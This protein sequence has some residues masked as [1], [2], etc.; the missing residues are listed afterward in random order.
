MEAPPPQYFRGHVSFITWSYSNA[1]LSLASAVTLRGEGGVPAFLLRY[2]P[3][4][5]RVNSW[6]TSEA[7]LAQM[8]RGWLRF[9]VFFP[10]LFLITLAI[11]TFFLSLECEHEKGEPIIFSLETKQRSGLNQIFP[12]LCPHFF[13]SHSLLREHRLECSD[14]YWK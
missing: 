6:H 10:L 13:A 3:E 7:G 8:R 2:K 12:P 14:D 11:E 9:F 4:A 1:F 5:S